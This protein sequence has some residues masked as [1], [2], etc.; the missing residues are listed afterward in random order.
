MY[1]NEGESSCKGVGMVRFV[2]ECNSEYGNGGICKRLND[3]TRMYKNEGE[4]S[5]KRGWHNYV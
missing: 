3:R 1:K 2:D 4:S 5:C